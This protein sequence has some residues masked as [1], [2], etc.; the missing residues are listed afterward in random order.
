M[1]VILPPALDGTNSLLMNRPVGKVN[2]LPF[3]AV[4]SASR[5][6]IVDARRMRAR[7]TPA[8]RGNPT[9]LSCPKGREREVVLNVCPNILPF[10]GRG[11][12]YC[13]ASSAELQKDKIGKVTCVGL[14]VLSI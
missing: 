5:F 6:A 11:K 12:A 8:R 14:N 13:F 2:R 4:R 7:R 1:L 9:G 10:P 3:G